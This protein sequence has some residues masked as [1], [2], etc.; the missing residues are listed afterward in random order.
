MRRL[1]CLRQRSRKNLEPVKTYL[2]IKNSAVLS[3]SWRILRSFPPLLTFNAILDNI[4]KITI[5]TKYAS[6]LV[7]IFDS[8][9]SDATIHEMVELL[10]HTSV[11]TRRSYV[12]ALESAKISGGVH[13]S[14]LLKILYPDD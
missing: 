5:Q 9:L 6:E 14:K 4:E 11:T 8:S 13:A 12:H 3:S 10:D 2:Y 7:D 1:K